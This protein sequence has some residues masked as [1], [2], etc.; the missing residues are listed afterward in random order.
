MTAGSI[1]AGGNGIADVPRTDNAQELYQVG[2]QH[3]LAGDYRAAEAVFRV[4]QE[5][6]PDDPMAGDASFWLGEAPLRAGAL[7]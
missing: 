6:Y 7:S 4:F 5:R 3:V 2:Y 1:P